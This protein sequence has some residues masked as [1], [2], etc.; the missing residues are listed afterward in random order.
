MTDHF[1][2]LAIDVRRRTSAIIRERQPELASDLA[3]EITIGIDALDSEGCHGFAQLLVRLMG[4]SVE[5]GT[6]DPGSTPVRELGGYCPP[7]ATRHILETVHGAE[8]IVLAEIALD[9][10]IGTT[11]E[12]W[13]LVTHAVHRAGLEILGAYADQIA[14]R[15]VPVVVRDGLTT[16][17]ASSVFELALAQEVQRAHRHKRALAVLLFDVDGLTEINRAY[18]RGVGDRVLERL[19][20]QARRFFRTHDWVARYGDD[21]IAVLLP[22]TPLDDAVVLAGR[23]RE[24]VEQRLVLS[25]HESDTSTIVTVSAA[26]VGTDLVQTDI[27]AGYVLAEAEGALMRAKLNGRNRVERVAL[28]PTS[29]TIFG[30]ATLLG[31][32]PREVTRLIRGGGLKAARRGRHFHIDRTAIENYRKSMR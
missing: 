3:A 25:D 14:G 17:L 9:E 6:L 27:D 21:G 19:G 30:A 15:E 12:A 20:I 31:R 26:V 11:S 23:F 4:M 7:L 5:S 8:R 2:P 13:P 28:L 1:S 24:M 29:L 32:T 18:G 16:L 10:S 22:E